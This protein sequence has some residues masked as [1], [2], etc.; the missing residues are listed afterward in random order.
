MGGGGGG[1][2]GASAIYNGDDPRLWQGGP[3]G[4]SGTLAR[5][6]LD[7]E[8]GDKLTVRVG[9]GGT[10]GAGGTTKQDADGNYVGQFGKPGEDGDATQVDAEADAEGYSV[11]APGGSSAGALPGP[12]GSAEGIVCAGKPL[13]KKAG[14]NGSSGSM[15][16][17]QMGGTSGDG[18]TPEPN[19]VLTK[20]C[21]GAGSGGAG[22]NSASLTKDLSSKSNGAV[23]GTGQ[24]GC[25]VL[26]PS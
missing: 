15:P 21:P 12:G 17:G 13:E 22:G 1:R 8:A 7:V 5:C 16:S 11:E 25:V 4:G 23:G 18:G 24:D 19:D 6:T 20:H 26:I 10:G 2:G 3:G 9:A 14:R